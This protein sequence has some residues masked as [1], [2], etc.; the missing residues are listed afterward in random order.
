MSMTTGQYKNPISKI[1][2]DMTFIMSSSVATIEQETI[3]KYKVVRIEPREDSFK[4]EVEYFNGYKF[5]GKITY[6]QNFK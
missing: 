2:N 5:E 1:L 6:P 3:D 4:L